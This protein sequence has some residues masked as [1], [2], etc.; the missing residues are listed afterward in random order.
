MYK[1]F[2]SSQFVFET[3]WREYPNMLTSIE[4]NIIKNKILNSSKEFCELRKKKYFY[5]KYLSEGGFGD[6]AT[7]G[8]N[9]KKIKAAI[10]SIGRNGKNNLFY[11]DTIIKIGKQHV[12]S[13]IYENYDFGLSITDPLSDMICGSVLGHLYDIGVCPFITKYFGSYMCDNNEISMISE[14]SDFELRSVLSLERKNRITPLELK[15]ILCQYSYCLFILK[16][17]FG[18]VHFD[19]HLRNIMLTDI[20]CKDY[21]YQGINLRNVKYFLF[22][23]DNENMVCLKRTNYLLKLIDYGTMSFDFNQSKQQRFRKNLRIETDFDDIR[24]IGAEE[25]LVLSRTNSSYANTVDIMFTLINLYEYFAKGLDLISSKQLNEEYIAV[26]DNFTN[27]LLGI[28]MTRFIEKNPQFKIKKML[29]GEYDWFMR[30]HSTGISEGYEDPIFFLKTLLSLC[31]KT[32]HITCPFKNTKHYGKKIKVHSYD[33][34]EGI[35]DQENTL[36]L[37]HNLSDYDL[38][39]NKFEKILEFN[40]KCVYSKHF[41]EIF[42]LFDQD[43]YES[44]KSEKLIESNENL[45]IVLRISNNNPKYSKENSWLNLNPVPKNK[46]GTQIEEVRLFLIELHKFFNVEVGMEDPMIKSNGLKIPI[47]NF[48]NFNGPKPLGYFA[49]EKHLY[50]SPTK[51]YYP[52]AYN[53][54]LSVLFFD[55]KL[56]IEKYNDFIGRHKTRITQHYINKNKVENINVID[57]PIIL[58][59][60]NKYKWA[61]TIGPILIWD[62]KNVFDINAK[63]EDILYG[64]SSEYIFKGNGP[65]YYS[66]TDSFELQPHLLFVQT[67]NRS[68]F[69][70]VEGSGFLTPG[71]DRPSLVKLCENLKFQYAVCIASGIALNIIFKNKNLSKSPVNLTR[72]S[73]LDFFL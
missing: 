19:S 57:K 21:F 63:S 31:D 41:C 11:V 68:G 54:Y 36:L 8:I 52:N 46:I 15:N 20:S 16:S 13:R 4:N 37:T 65:G 72:G 28:S 58:K 56:N 5:L 67:K 70:F 33:F 51:L 32:Y 47:G 18:T 45:K 3:L 12:K 60:G 73:S 29:N 1:S 61:V 24:K 66:M 69:I 42:E 14:K 9:N 44:F 50:M 22:E 30:N 27:N 39:F 25:A 48:V 38:L 64:N 2:D 35:I 23:I 55:G 40:E 59:S 49:S 6:V 53:P 43:P 34:L 10:F 71:L 17:Y 7:I 26:I 62:Y